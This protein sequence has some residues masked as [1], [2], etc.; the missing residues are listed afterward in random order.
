M[1]K[2]SSNN[3][4]A[5]PR[6][7]QLKHLC[8]SL[9]ALE[10][11]LSPSWEYRYYSYNKNWAKD[12]ECCTMR[13]GSGDEMLILF[14]KT[15]T[16]INGFAHENTCRDKDLITKNLPEVFD[17][18]IF[19]EPVASIGTTFCIWA[20]EENQEWISNKLG[21]KDG[22]T[23]LLELLDGKP[24]TFQ[25]WAIDYY[26]LENLNLDIIKQIYEHNPITKELIQAL[27]PTLEDFQQL[28]EDLEEIGYE[29]KL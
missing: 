7:T 23:E 3:L 13:N 15:G 14:T 4:A 20:I 19:G 28:K 21:I 2:L 25:Q 29:Y 17:S 9:A 5:L 26:E 18:F 11:I 8:Q 12:E 6:P 27:N 24:E 22:S 10:A 16:I 1:E